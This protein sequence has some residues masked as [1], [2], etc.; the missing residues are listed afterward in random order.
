[1]NTCREIWISAKDLW[2]AWRRFKKVSNGRI[3]IFDVLSNYAE[4][5]YED[6]YKRNTRR[7]NDA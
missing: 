7:E 1:M 2:V 5:K 6:D 3:S 4:K